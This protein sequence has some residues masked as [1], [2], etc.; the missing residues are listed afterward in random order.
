HEI[1]DDQ[2]AVGVIVLD[3]VIVHLVVVGGHDHD[4]DAVGHLGD[5]R[6][7]DTEVHGVVRFDDVVVHVGALAVLHRQARKIEHE[8]A[9]G[10]VVRVIVHHLGVGRVLDL[11]A[12]DV[13]V[14]LA[15]LHDDVAGLA[16]VY[17]G[18]A[19]ALD[20]AAVDPDAAAADGI[21]TVGAARHGLVG[22]PYH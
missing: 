22:V 13:A 8:D 14:A 10:V 20:R 11:D 4:A 21:E 7:H 3:H 17:P 2:D 15:V 16:H 6:A 9:T 19:R 12:G 18:V 1:A 5:G